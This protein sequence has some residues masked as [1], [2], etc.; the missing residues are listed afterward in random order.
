ML[1]FSNGREL[2]SGIASLTVLPMCQGDQASSS[3]YLEILP[4]FYR[5][6]VHLCLSQQC[7]QTCDTP[8]I[9]D[10]EHHPSLGIYSHH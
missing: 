9:I 6:G 7:G 3:I 5:H 8:I 4:Q 1:S 2:T 10:S